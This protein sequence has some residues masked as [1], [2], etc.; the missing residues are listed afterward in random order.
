M[1]EYP[2][3]PQGS[4]SLL[5]G[6]SVP[7]PVPFASSARNSPLPWRNYRQDYTP[8]PIAAANWVGSV[9]G[10][11]PQVRYPA[12][13]FAFVLIDKPQQGYAYEANSPPHC[14][15]ILSGIVKKVL[16]ERMAH[17]ESDV[18]AYHKESGDHGKTKITVTFETS[19]EI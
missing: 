10:P 18:I 19:G 3:A 4:L 1:S 9:G 17:P 5:G 13:G 12:L 15:G 14:R 8:F 7:P 11:Q 6:A 16:N 2:Q